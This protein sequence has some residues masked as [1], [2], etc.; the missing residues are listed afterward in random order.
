MECGWR[1]R[2]VAQ[3][4][5]YDLIF[6]PCQANNLA[7]DPGSMGITAGLRARLDE[8]MIATDDPLLRGPLSW[9]EGFP[10]LD[11]DKTSPSEIEW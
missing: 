3:E 4:Q 7:G 2:P 5:L 10:G 6:D 9:P 8:W 1:E 11:P